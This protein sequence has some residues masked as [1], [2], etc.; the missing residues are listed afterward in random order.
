MALIK[1]IKAREILD[2]RG[3]PT[4][5]VECITDD[6]IFID[7][8]P[9]GASKGE[10]EAIELRDGGTRFGGKGVL[11][12]VDVINKV[13]GPKIIGLDP[14]DQ[15]QI[16]KLMIDLD[17]T[18]NK[19]KLGA[20]SIL[21]I[22]MAVCR[23]GAKSKNLELYEYISL[24]FSGRYK[25]KYKIPKCCFNVINGGKHAGNNLSFQEFMI[26]PNAESFK[27]ELRIASEIYYALKLKLKTNYSANAIN[28]GDEGGFAPPIDVPEVALGNI[29]GAIEDAG[30]EEKVSIVLDVA[31][32]SFFKDE[33][34]SLS[35]GA[36]N[37]DEFIEYYS[38]L[39]SSYPIIGIEDPL[40]EN[41]WKGFSEITKK[42][43]KDIMI[44]GD[45]LLVSNVEY[46]KKAKEKDS[47]NAVLLK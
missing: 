32:S 10:R 1:E 24:L 31:A 45:D 37:K 33:Y 42:M 46:I 43:G 35:T 3:N 14:E 7:S 41:D 30:F 47:C 6:N 29:I 22:S 11:K 5:E 13:I 34:Y 39:I 8:V 23:A 19:S 20:N 12:A 17:G 40:E 4:I 25:R 21:G 44:I 27:E 9:A 26:V 15:E 38:D 18:S 2:S 36:Y 16:D 28:V